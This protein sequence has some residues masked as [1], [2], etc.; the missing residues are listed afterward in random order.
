M[1]APCESLPFFMNEHQKR[2]QTPVFLGFMKYFPDAIQ[3]VARVS[4]ICNE[5]HNPGEPVH[6][7]KEKSQDELDAL[8]RHLLDAGTMDSDGMRHSAK[9]A[10]R[11]M[12][13]LQREIDAEKDTKPNRSNHKHIGR[14]DN[15]HLGPTLDLSA[16]R[17]R[18]ND[19]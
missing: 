9:V 19:N 8:A 2:K 7:A 17:D 1:G 12:A 6:W 14:P 11:A 4:F 3:E 18:V 13:N 10:W 16:I 5:Q 15:K